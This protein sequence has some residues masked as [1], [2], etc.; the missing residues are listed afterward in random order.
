MGV[1]ERCRQKAHRLSGRLV[2]ASSD[3]CGQNVLK[4]KRE[5]GSQ[6][7]SVWDEIQKAFHE[8]TGNYL[9]TPGSTPHGLE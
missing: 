6:K 2:E 7:G 9:E 8:R 3:H 5:G 1:L 4:T